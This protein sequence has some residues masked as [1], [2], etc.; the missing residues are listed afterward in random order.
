MIDQKR[1]DD[2]K[3]QLLILAQMKQLM[4][5][6]ARELSAEDLL[7][8]VVYRIKEQ[9]DTE[10]VNNMLRQAIGEKFCSRNALP[11]EFVDEFGF[12]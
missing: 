12:T 6:V 2:L 11:E 8:E 7:R 9:E 4:E 1:T 5:F 10:F 3:E